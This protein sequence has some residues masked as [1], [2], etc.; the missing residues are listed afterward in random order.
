MQNKERRK[1]FTK[2]RQVDNQ[3]IKEAIDQL[4]ITSV[5]GVGFFGLLSIAAIP[6]IV[7]YLD[8][9]GVI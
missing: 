8:N 5:V 2:R 7:F 3:M 9:M 1:D 4:Y 6:S